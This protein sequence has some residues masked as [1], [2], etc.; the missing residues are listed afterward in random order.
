MKVSNLDYFKITPKTTKLGLVPFV[1][2][3]L[4]LTWYFEAS[5][6]NFPSTFCL[7]QITKLLFLITQ[8]EREKKFRTG[9]V[10]YADRVFK[11]N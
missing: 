7:L 4:C 8:S 5:R 9:Q 6:V 3:F 1:G 10:A 2:T 11:F